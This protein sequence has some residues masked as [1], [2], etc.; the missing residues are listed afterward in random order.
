MQNVAPGV[1]NTRYHSLCWDI[2][3]NWVDSET[4]VAILKEI[5]LP[6]TLHNTYVPD[7]WDV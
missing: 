7:L 4:L 1:Y 2:S 5:Y 3:G 6:I